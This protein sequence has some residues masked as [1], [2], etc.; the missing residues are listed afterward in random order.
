MPCWWVGWLWRAGCISQDTYLLYLT[1]PHD[2]TTFQWAKVVS[3][4]ILLL[5]NCENAV[6]NLSPQLDI[7]D[8]L[9]NT[10]LNNINPIIKAPNMS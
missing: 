6:F 9:L 4:A 7:H 3:E 2:K 8:A 1:F 5:T 10:N